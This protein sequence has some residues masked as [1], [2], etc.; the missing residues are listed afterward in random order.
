MV[1]PS[2]PNQQDMLSV[3]LQTVYLF[4]SVPFHRDLEAWAVLDLEKDQLLEGEVVP[5]VLQVVGAAS[6]P[7]ISS[8]IRQLE[9]PSGVMMC[10]K[11]RPRAL[12]LVF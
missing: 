9:K 1:G 6:P 7:P 12:V 8:E 3:Q 5:W 11:P 2:S 4:L 10:W